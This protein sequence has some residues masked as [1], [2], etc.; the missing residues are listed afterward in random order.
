MQYDYQRKM[1]KTYMS[2]LTLRLS[3]DDILFQEPEPIRRDITRLGQCLETLEIWVSRSLG[4]PLK[5]IKF[6]VFVAS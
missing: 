3:P 2:N 1:Q 6:F 4:F 5:Y